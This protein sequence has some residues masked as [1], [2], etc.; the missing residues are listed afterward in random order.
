ED[1]IQL[2]RAKGLKPFYVLYRYLVRNAILPQI[3]AFAITLGSL[4]SGQVLVEYI[5]GYQGMGNIIF[6]AI[7]SQDFPVIQGA[8][9]M[10]IVITALA[11]LIMDLT[12]PL[13][14]PRISYERN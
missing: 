5:F 10:L 4:V 12:Y 8:S 11:V 6:A 7:T 14:D 13:I 9:F 3:T 2:A 1:Y